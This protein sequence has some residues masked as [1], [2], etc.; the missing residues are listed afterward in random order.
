MRAVCLLVVALFTL[1]CG[2]LPVGDPVGVD[3]VGVRAVPSAST[4]VTVL[5]FDNHTG[6]PA[7][8]AFGKGLADMMIT[9]LSTVDDL[10]VVE[11]A[12]LQALIDEMSLQQSEYFDPATAQKLGQGLGATHAI[13]GSI[14]AFAPQ[15]RIDIRLIDVNSSEVVLAE[16][17]TGSDQ[18]IF[19]LQEQL[20]STF[21]DA[22]DKR[23]EAGE[24]VDGLAADGLLAY[25]QGLEAADRGDLETA[26]ELLGRVVDSTP[27]FGL[28]QQRLTDV[29]AQLSASRERREGMLSAGQQALLANIDAE[30]KRDPTKLSGDAWARYYA[31]RSVR[32]GLFLTTADK[33][34][35]EPPALED[36]DMFTA[37]K[38]RDD[39]DMLLRKTFDE[40][41]QPVV[42]ELLRMWF[43][44]SLR[45][46]QEVAAY[47]ATGKRLPAFPKLDDE[48]EK[49]AR[50]LGVRLSMGVEPSERTVVSV[51]HVALLGRLPNAFAGSRPT[52]AQLDPTVV[53]P[54]LALF[55]LAT[56]ALDPGDERKIE[57][58]EAHGEVLVALGRTDEGIA[59]WQQIL[60]EFPTAIVYDKIEKLI[61][62]HS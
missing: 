36:L 50:A 31:Y 61:R 5:Y 10:A 30:L 4:V 43:D 60:D 23:R 39:P 49:R 51:G 20:A 55:Q 35:K 54:T 26:S 47:E 25:G 7:Y 62:D 1:A 37:M 21:A 29:D 32:G 46:H 48:D 12:K 27:G 40:A 28:A 22:L 38:L 15:I 6:D 41:D 18:D 17:V 9:D 19:G 24:P 34:L 45:M 42:R 13:T 8:D 3:G 33:L 56:E 52:L 53:A 44:N 59:R 58:L 14:N 2:G 16:G 57:L 11:R